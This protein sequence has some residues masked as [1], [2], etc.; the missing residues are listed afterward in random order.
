QG[1]VPCTFTTLTSCPFRAATTLGR[2]RSEKSENFWSRL[3]FS[4]MALLRRES[5]LSDPTIAAYQRR[6]YWLSQTSPRD[7]AVALRPAE[8]ILRTPPR[9]V[10]AAHET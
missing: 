1:K 7:D 8:P 2:H 3:N 10:F 5:A 6:T 9:L 4:G